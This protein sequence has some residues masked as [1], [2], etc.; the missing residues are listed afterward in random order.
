MVLG[1]RKKEITA[2]KQRIG[3]L[4]KE[5]DSL[6]QI[7]KKSSSRENPLFNLTSLQKL[8]ESSGI[9]L[10]T[11]TS[12]KDKLWLSIT[13][14]E[15]LGYKN[16]TII[17]LEN[18][19]NS[20]LPEDK[21]VFE[22]ALSDVR[23][24]FKIAEFEIKIAR[25]DGDG[26]EF[27]LIAMNITGITIEKSDDNKPFECAGYIKDIT[28]QDKIRRDLIRARERAEDSEK[29]KNTLLANISHEIRTP[30]NSIIGFS[31]LLNIGN[32]PYD[33]KVEYVKTIKNQGLL[34]LKMIDDVVELTRI[35][36]G[37]ATIRKSPCN[38]NL[39]MKEMLT[40]FNKYKVSQNKEHLEI[41]I[42][43]PENRNLVIYTDP[44]RL[45]QILSSL[46]NNS[47]KY[48]EKGGIE[49]GY[50]P[51]S[52]QRIE[53]YVKDSGIGLSRDLQKRL[54]GR[55]PEEENGGGGRSDGSGLGLTIA[56]NL[57]RMMGGKIWVES[58]L[59]QGSTFFFTIPYEEV[60][61]TYHEMGPEEEYVIPSYNWKDK[62]IVIAE[63]DEINFKFLEAVLLDTSAQ[64]LHAR[65]GIEAVELCR[66]INKIDL[67]LMDLKM[68]EMDGFEATRHIRQFNRKI[69]IIMQTA[70]IRD[71]ELPR[72]EEI[73]CNDY[74]TK[75]IEIKE[76]F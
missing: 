2:L 62:V 61:A 3:D 12:E 8:F 7:V 53:F 45:Q 26:R 28:R 14:R 76:F 5:I 63:D 34:L 10:W 52:E 58:E 71:D 33:K 18:V 46:L 68:P 48:T 19:R 72:C 15:I 40:F 41:R 29:L 69:P 67:V 16:E 9:G 1:N 49:I 54:F 44:G 32:L 4:E 43:Y 64:I 42:I 50:K 35:E 31:E 55:P 65:N 22:K 37:K 47:I 20:I 25:T 13:A 38:L 51:I 17:T 27:R 36:T 6:N 56:K 70:F 30:M 21:P 24:G 23:Q 59:G 39:M 74:I 73:G 11:F 60:P 75:P 66:S 57:I